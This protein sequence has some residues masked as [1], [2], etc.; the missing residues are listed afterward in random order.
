MPRFIRLLSVL[1]AACLV[2]AVAPA[3]AALK[4]LAT[5][6]DWASLTTELGG[7]KVNVY[8]ATSAF[9]DVHRVDAKPSLVARARSADLVV[10]TGAD[11]EIGWM[12]VLLQDSGNTRIQPGSPGYF[13]AAPLVHL[14]EVPSAV[15]RSMGDIHPLGNPHVTLNPHNITII[16]AA[17][18]ARLAQV[19]PANAAFYQQRGAD[20]QKRWTEATV[21]WEAAAAPLKGI[22]VVVIHRDQVYL[23]NWLGLKELAAIEPK[24]GVPPSAGYLA[25]LVT[26]LGATPPKMILRNAYNDPKAAD[27]LAER[28]HVPVVLLP[29][30]VGGTPE[31]KDLFGLFD[32][33]VNRLLA[34]AK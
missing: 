18:S 15:D 34:A 11:L 3:Q 24:P 27:W 19:D 12:P 5:T 29:Y 22:G 17:L 1:C 31:A 10:A 23:C 13:E 30:S 28:I 16:A 6:P 25:E 9:Q 20:F 26:K 33:T 21:K 4:V 14:L 8:T 32:D 2:G 7:D